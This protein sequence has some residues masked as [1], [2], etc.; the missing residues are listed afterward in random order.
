MKMAARPPSREITT[1]MSGMNSAISRVTTN[2]TRVVMTRRR[3]SATSRSAARGLLTSRLSMATLSRT[4]TFFTVQFYAEYAAPKCLQ[5][6]H[7]KICAVLKLKLVQ[8][9]NSNT[10][11]FGLRIMRSGNECICLTRATCPLSMQTT[12]FMC[13]NRPNKS[14]SICCQFY[15]NCTQQDSH[16]Y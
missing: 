4:V 11:S 9:Y 16:Q 6:L 7:P 1:P 12:L 8:K 13:R 10:A 14:I 2:Q 5:Q 3:R 15:L